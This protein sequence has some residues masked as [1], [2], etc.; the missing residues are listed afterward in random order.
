M[1]FISV[2][3]AGIIFSIVALVLK[4][5]RREYALIVSVAG[6]IFI[7]LAALKLLTPILDGVKIFLNDSETEN[8]KI[9]LRA[10]GI[11]Y[12]TEFASDVAKDAGENSLSSKIEMFGKAAVIAVSFP[13]LSGLFEAIR[14]LLL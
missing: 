13:I 12:L 4:D 3:G 6:G 1:S 10:L 8:I 7:V 5:K 9:I 11:G 2:L 14:E